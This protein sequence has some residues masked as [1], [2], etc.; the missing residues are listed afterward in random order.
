MKENINPIKPGHG[1][2]TILFGMTIAQ[3]EEILGKPDEVDKGEFDV[4]NE[5][6]EIFM[7][8]WHYDEAE[9]SMEFELIEGQFRLV[10]LSVTG[11]QYIYK[12]QKLIG[13]TLKEL[14]PLIEDLY[15]DKDDSDGDEVVVLFSD[16]LNISFWF[17]DDVLN[18][19]QWSQVLADVDMN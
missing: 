2:G 3:V 15:L 1:L 12:D 10:I 11:E 4:P 18:E 19:V 16:L 13:K 7:Q 17:E 5:D 6:E 9:L 8:T 14:K